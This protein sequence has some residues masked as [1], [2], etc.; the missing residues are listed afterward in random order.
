[1]S[2]AGPGGLRLDVDCRPDEVGSVVAIE[3]NGEALPGVRVG[4]VTVEAVDIEVD[5]RRRTVTVSWAPGGVVDVD[6]RLGHT[7]LVL[8]GPGPP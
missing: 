5:G 1:M 7:E 6:S 8:L 3:V 2:F 4:T